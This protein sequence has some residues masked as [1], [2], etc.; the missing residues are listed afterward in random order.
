MSFNDFVQLFER[1]REASSKK[2]KLYLADQGTTTFKDHCTSSSNGAV[3]K[4][5]ESSPNSDDAMDTGGVVLRRNSRRMTLPA[6]LQKR[7]R[8]LPFLSPIHSQTSPVAKR[9]PSNDLTGILHVS[10][11][12]THAMDFTTQI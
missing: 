11:Y 8:E 6:R 5:V 9:P 12:Y 7:G 2:Q 1:E 3:K 10:K 4:Y